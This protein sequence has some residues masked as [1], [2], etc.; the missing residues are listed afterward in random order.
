MA[1]GTWLLVIGLC[2]LL[3]AARDTTTGVRRGLIAALAVVLL[4]LAGVLVGID[5]SEWIGLGA[6][7][8]VG[9]LLWLLGSSAA[10]TDRQ[11]AQ[12]AVV[13]RVVAFLG[14]A[15]GIVVS[16]LGGGVIE[17]YGAP[18]SILE[19]TLLGQIGLDH[20]VL[21]L[22]V[23]AI[24]L[25]T[26]NIAIRL[27]LD[28]VGVPASAGEK[29]LKGGRMLGPMERLLILGLGIA[30]SLT[31]ATIV[32]AAKGLL[33][34]PE[35]QRGSAEGGASD[36]TEYFLIGSFASWLIALGGVGLVGLSTASGGGWAMYFD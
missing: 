22:G 27:V 11:D 3:R 14:L 32:V 13:A 17:S 8:I 10:L 33:R 19:G 28:S 30:G 25:S 24:Q 6:A 21:V 23:V 26:A 7:W 4:V 16:V 18:A 1:L 2:D 36:V 9:A 31:A 34:F 15:V 12:V 35:L 5:G 29:Q 20:L